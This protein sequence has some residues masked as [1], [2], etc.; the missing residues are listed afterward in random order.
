MVH[1]RYRGSLFRDIYFVR[2]ETLAMRANDK[3]KLNNS[4]KATLQKLNIFVNI[5]K[6][7]EYH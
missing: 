7:S 2:S 1:I 4:I 5:H 6:Y 3:V